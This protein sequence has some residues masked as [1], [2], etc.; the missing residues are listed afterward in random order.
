MKVGSVLYLAIGIVL[1]LGIIVGMQNYIRPYNYEGAVINPPYPATD[2]KLTDQTG[3]PFQLSE[4]HGKVTL[5]FFG[6][7]QC[8]DICPATLAE[9]KQIHAKLGNEA[10]NAAF[11]FIT[12]DP[13][14]DTPDVLIKYLAKFGP[15][16]TGL[17]GTRNQLLPVWKSYGVYQQGIT[18]AVSLDSMVDHSSYVYVIDRSGNVRETFSFGDPVGNMMQDVEHLI[19]G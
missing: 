5:L 4:L 6:F 7:S 19:K 8:A 14:H 16:I 13:E 15:A 3:Q 1:G 18:S 10:K 12:V 11:V 17:T 9:F 2:F